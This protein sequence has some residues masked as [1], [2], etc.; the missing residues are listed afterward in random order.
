MKKLFRLLI[1]LVFILS[2][3][4][5]V[6][7]SADEAEDKKV[8]I[9]FD[10]MGGTELEPI[11]GIAGET[12]ITSDM[13]PAP[14]KEG[15][16]FLGWRH[17]NEYGAPFEL[18]VFPNYDIK[19]VAAFKPNG[20]T[21]NF[22]GSINSTFDYNSG[23]ELYGTKTENYDGKL[24][25][26][27]W[28]C[29]RTVRGNKA[30]LFL[31]SYQNRL[32]AGYEYEFTIY[33]KSE[34]NVGGNVEFVYLNNPDI[35]DKSAG[36]YWAFNISDMKKNEWCKYTVKFIAAAPY[37]AVKMPNV[38]GLYI[39]D[40]YVEK[41]GNTRPLPKLE[42]ESNSPLIIIMLIGSVVLITS[43]SIVIDKMNKNKKQ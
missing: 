33:L 10:S 13:L 8:T 18:E 42:K 3:C 23:I 7:V 16:T 17:F 36:E 34:N 12:K 41:T 21:V 19:L 29:L 9:S 15:Y 5:P 11:T 30:P 22:E 40:V 28:N 24:V 27:G 20:F 6:A 2:I 1:V 4:C 39:E 37:L 35:R 14:T 26:S 25:K 32:E 38:D 31:L 43:V